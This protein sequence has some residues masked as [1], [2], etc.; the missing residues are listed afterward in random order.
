MDGRPPFRTVLLHGLVRDPHGKKMSK[1]RGNV[2]DPLEWMDKYGADATRLSLFQ[3]AN[4][5]AD[6]AINEEWVRGTRNFCNKL[7]NATRFALL[8]GATVDGP[9]PADRTGADDWILS[10]LHTVIGE[11]DE[12]YETFEFAKITDLLYHF[13]WDEVCDWY[14]ELAKIQIAAGRPGTRRV[15]GEVLDVLLRLLHPMIPFVT[16]ALW[17]ALTG[18]ESVVIADWPTPDKALRN[19]EAEADIAALQAV[20]TEVRRFRS[21]QGVPPA[22]PVPARI[23]GLRDAHD[24]PVRELLRLAQPQDG[25]TPTAEVTTAA[26]VRVEVDL[27]GSIDVAAERARLSKARAAAEKEVAQNERK[28]ANPSFT[29]K[30]PADVVANVRARVEAAKAELE[31]VDQAMASLPT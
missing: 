11:V 12:L 15:L 7:W 28:L 16:E 27:S 30:A 17:T 25:F 6:Q 23:S 31:R 5:G 26:G 10:R 2:V 21:E 8:N 13:A 18:R 22:R 29:D 1:S 20:V 9:L 19:D 3:G 14:L 24:G 4:P